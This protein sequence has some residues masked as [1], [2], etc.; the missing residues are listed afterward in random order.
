MKDSSTRAARTVKALSVFFAVLSLGSVA[1]LQAQAPYVIP[2]TIQKLAGGGKVLSLNPPT[3][4]P[5]LG[6]GS[7][8]VTYDDYGDGCQNTSSSIV[9]GAGAALANVQDVGIDPQ[10]NL[11][12]LDLNSSN[13]TSV[14][15][16]DARSGVIT[17]VAGSLT[18][19]S[20]CG[21]TGAP[22]S[23]GTPVSA[24]GDG[25][26]ASDGLA[27][28]LGLHT[29]MSTV[30]GMV[31]APNGDF[32]LADYQDSVVQKISASTGIMTL[33]AGMLNGSSKSAAG[34]AGFSGNGGPATAAGVRSPRG[35]GID[36]A[37]NVYV[38]DTGNN[39]IRMVS[40]ATGIIT[41][42]AGSPVATSGS[43]GDGGPATSATLLTP[44]DVKVDSQ[45]NV[46]ICDFGNA[47]IRVVYQAGAAVAN[48]I[49]KTNS[50]MV[51]V[52]G[53]IYT[54]LGNATGVAPTGGFQL[55]TSIATAQIRH[56]QVDAQDNLWV[57]DAGYNV[58]YFVDAT[59]GYLRI[60]AGEVSKTSGGGC[61]A[62]TDAFGDNCPATQATVNPNSALSVIPDGNGNLYI[63]DSGDVL[64][65]KVLSGRDFPAIAAGTS[66]TQ[67]ID[68]HFAAG[69]DPSA[70][71]P[72]SMTGNADFVIGTPAC[73]VNADATQDCLVPV[74][75]KPST[76]ARESAAI[77]VSSQLNG[78]SV[79]GVQGSGLAAEVALDP[80]AVSSAATGLKLPLGT[81]V[82]AIG[83][84][85][86]ADTGN[87]RV[88][89]YSSSGASMV[90]AGT[91]VAGYTGDNGQG[92]L[93]TLSAPSA[94]AVTPGNLIYIADT[95]NNVVRVLN[96]ITGVISTVAG[97]A[98]TICGTSRD[99]QGDGCVGTATK[100]SKP[101][102][103]A[104]DV[105]G[106]VY[107]SDTGD[108]MIRE[109]S[110]IGYVSLVAG[111][112]SAVCTSTS[113]TLI[114]DSFGNNC[115]PTQAI[116]NGPTGL[117]IDSNMNI[118]IA[119]TGNSEVRKIVAAGS[120]VVNLAGTGVAGA[121]SNGG[122]ATAAQVNAPTGV[123]VDAAGNVYIADTGNQAVRMVPA[124]GLI[125]TVLGTL[126][127]SGNGTLPGAATTTALSSPSSVAVLPSGNLIVLDSANN[128]VIADNRGGVAYNFGRTNIG[129][130]SPTLSISETEVGS[131]AAS[132]GSPLLASS[133][134][135]SYFALNGV[136]STG[137]SNGTN[138]GVGA[139]CAL[140]AV[141][142]PTTAI[143]NQSVS[144]SYLEQSSNTV[145]TTVP[146]I[147]LSGFAA[148]LT[149]TSSA[150]ALTTPNVTPQYAVP[151]S[152]TTTV[153]AV[154]CNTAAPTCYP[155]GN[156]TV[157]VDGQPVGTSALVP[158]TGQSASA[159]LS[160]SSAL[161]VGNHSLTA[162][163]ST[164]GFYAS[165]TSRC[166]RSTSLP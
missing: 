90:L 132:L 24:Y 134:S 121:G 84:T 147:N 33:V 14:R 107:V 56:V 51:A 38:A 49:S 66:A 111:G 105:Y 11:F 146:F 160:I 142:S 3:T 152:V 7:I 157:S 16:L 131:Q 64:L 62:Q 13:R 115:P 114:V 113:A 100:F 95:G 71:N 52:P 6:T 118:Y 30:R 123:G 8:G 23:Y 40:A 135:S 87:N 17:I 159:T 44:V 117:A 5:C 151:F 34:V 163:Y 120:L 28:A 4:A 125:N 78:I 140:S 136:G 18:T 104:A 81:A 162:V 74:T 63:A 77:S 2:Y 161:A 144:G 72:F 55:A 98:K 68:V 91:G 19:A 150:I 26:V 126:G 57:A 103:L 9:I 45:G 165:N 145:N 106:N 73:T 93:A 20:I 69:D 31:V 166:L 10:G 88:V 99:A 53:N 1:S 128:R 46:F 29:S 116:F 112:A 148:V 37:G 139:G 85:Y 82:D 141:F 12:F 110:P 35:V 54:V 154:A 27:N 101:A 79:I 61:A 138:L 153:T 86:V 59:T 58:V 122:P 47:K 39:E 76:G 22:A 102:G 83:N 89:V 143:L 164:D 109:I 96:P 41:N 21:A 65:R 156:V 127:T 32:Y 119:D 15:R 155:A 149:N 129:S 108:N 67:T 94:V 80:G 42:I 25:C 97:G 130:S 70:L 137:C 124:S 36:S 75:F 50:G 48:L 92:I 133:G 43:G 158:S 60:V